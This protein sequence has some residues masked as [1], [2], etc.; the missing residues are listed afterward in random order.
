MCEREKDRDREAA[1]NFKPQEIANLLWAL[2]VIGQVFPL[3]LNER[4]RA[5]ER[6]RERERVCVCVCVIERE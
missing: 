2:V 5:S 4:E 6:E 3:F 1:P